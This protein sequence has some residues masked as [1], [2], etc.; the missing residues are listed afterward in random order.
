MDGHDRFGSVLT[1][2]RLCLSLRIQAHLLPD[3]ALDLLFTLSDLVKSLVCGLSAV[4]L[5]L[6]KPID[7][8]H[9]SPLGSFCRGW[10]LGSRCG[11]VSV[12]RIDACFPSSS[13]T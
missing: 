11:A 10:M 7:Q 13:S 6:A 8:I 2:Q 3:A 1:V 12:G 5:G 9:H 4:L